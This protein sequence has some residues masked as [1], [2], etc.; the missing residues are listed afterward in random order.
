LRSDT[1]KPISLWIFGFKWLTNADK[2]LSSLYQATRGTTLFGHVTNKMDPGIVNMLLR[3][4][5]KSSKS[6]LALSFQTARQAL[7]P[8]ISHRALTADTSGERTLLFILLAPSLVPLSFHSFTA[9]L[10]YC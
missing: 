6:F 2:S 8:V 1:D 9:T 5:R 7:L 4:M 10:S 3:K